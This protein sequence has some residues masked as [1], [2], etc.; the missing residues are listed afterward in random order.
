MIACACFYIRFCL[1]IVPMK[2]KASEALKI[3]EAENE[4]LKI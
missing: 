1:E 2:V 4:K 3:I